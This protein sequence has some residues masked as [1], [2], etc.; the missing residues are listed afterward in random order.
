MGDLDNVREAGTSLD[1]KLST[2]EGVICAGITAAAVAAA[3]AG[4]IYGAPFMASLP[5]GATLWIALRKTLAYVL[6]RVNVDIMPAVDKMTARE[7]V[8]LSTGLTAG[9]LALMGAGMAHDAPFEKGLLGGAALAAI[10][11]ETVESWRR[12]L[13]R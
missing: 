10:L 4:T 9:L 6:V 11:P 12:Y 3:Y 8:Y 1:D 2:K 13:R 7:R 5:V